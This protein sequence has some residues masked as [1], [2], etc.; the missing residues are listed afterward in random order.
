M[1]PRV[2]PVTLFPLL[3]FNFFAFFHLPP[4]Y[5]IGAERTEPRATVLWISMDGVRADYLD[6][7]PL[8]FFERMK[9]GGAWSRALRPAFPPITFPSHCAQATGV[10][11]DHHGVTGNS[12]YDTATR[13]EYRYPAEAKLLGAEPIWLTAT[14]QGVRTLVLDWPLS[15]NQPGPVRTEYFETRF[16]NAPT[17]DARLERMLDLWRRDPA[18]HPGVTPLRLLMGYV[19]AADPVG[20][21]LGPDAPEI[22]PAMQALDHTLGLF[23]ENAVTLWK[24]GAGR[25]AGEE[26]YL[27]LT[28]D[29]GMSKVE[30]VVNLERLLGLS[31]RVSGAPLE[32][33]PMIVTVGNLGHV[34]VPADLGEDPRAATLERL[35]QTLRKCEFLRV[36]RRENLPPAW[37][38]RHPTRTG[39]LVVVLN[40]GYSFDRS[41]PVAVV[42]AAP[43]LL[44]MHGYPV[45]DDPEMLGA[46]FLWRAG[47]AAGGKDLGEVR[48]DQ[49]HPT[50]ARLLHVQP[51][52]GADGEPLAL[53]VV[54]P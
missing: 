9:A 46:C 23:V 29:H 45:E 10:P 17:D 25:E 43:G 24:Q 3:V 37:N 44:G 40:Q 32:G 51:A 48:W 14:R 52:E 4:G 38:Y 36:F 8:P 18:A 42:D 33:A 19:H 1:F 11:A 22:A 6:R 53:P 27:L 13:R 21:R 16:D 34:F 20:H 50:V 47:A 54:S 35:E 2:R 12:F 41:S 28:T 7:A 39:D 15:Q 5:L 26:F 31:S 49:L 30:K